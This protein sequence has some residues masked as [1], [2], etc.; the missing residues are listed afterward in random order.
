MRFAGIWPTLAVFIPFGASMMK[1]KESGHGHGGMT[2][3]GKVP[4][5]PP[6]PAEPVNYYFTAQYKLNTVREELAR[7]DSNIGRILVD[8]RQAANFE[9]RP[10]AKI[11]AKVKL[12]QDIENLAISRN[13]PRE[14]FAGV[15]QFLALDVQD[16][17]RILSQRY[18]KD[19]TREFKNLCEELCDRHNQSRKVYEVK[20]DNPDNP[21]ICKRAED[22]KVITFIP[23]QHQAVVDRMHQ[24]C[25]FGGSDRD[26]GSMLIDW[27]AS[28][29]AGWQDMAINEEKGPFIHAVTRQSTHE[30]RYPC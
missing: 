8:F 9:K 27:V 16:D 18:N 25:T 2:V 7:I 30:M 24:F 21:D 11:L 17:G 15:M 26:L 13:I 4:A 29:N 20:R 12:P 28:A 1:A 19:R 10:D 23:D 6:A 3:N 22:G 5:S 14:L